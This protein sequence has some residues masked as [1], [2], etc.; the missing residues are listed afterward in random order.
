MACLLKF[1]TQVPVLNFAIPCLL[2][3]RFSIQCF[4]M[5]GSFE[6]H[7]QIVDLPFH[8]IQVRKTREIKF[9]GLDNKPQNFKTNYCW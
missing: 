6:E 1:K 2:T 3:L 8:R 9:I 5:Y 7:F 4:T